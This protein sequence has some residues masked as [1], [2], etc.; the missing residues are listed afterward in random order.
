MQVIPFQFS[1]FIALLPE[2][3]L[4]IT[5]GS[6]ALADIALPGLR[7]KRLLGVYTAIGIGLA[8]LAAVLAVPGTLTADLWFGGMIRNDVAA[9]AFRL[10]ILFAGMV[11][12]LITV[13]SPAIGKEGEF[14]LV[15]TGATLGMCMMA[16][17]ADLIMLYLAIETTSIGLYALAGYLRENDKSAESGLKYFLF[18]AFTSTLLLYGFSLL[19]GFTGSTNLFEIGAALSAGAVPSLPL[20]LSLVLILIGLGF[21]IS[22]VPFHFWTPDVYEGAPTP[23]TAFLSVASKAA[24]FAVLMRVLL[25]AFPGY[26]AWWLQV[27]AAL[28]ALTMTVGNVL[29]MQQRNL[30]RLLAYSSIAQ[31]G[32]ILMGL[33]AFSGQQ[34]DAGVGAVVYYL[35]MYTLTNLA[36]FGVMVLVGRVTGSD[37][38]AD[39]SGLSRRSPG[40][41]LAMLVALLSLGGVP[42]LAGF[43]GKFYLFA[44]VAQNPALLWLFVVGLINAIVSLYYYLVV[45][46]VIYLGQPKDEASLPVSRPYIAALWL[47]AVG[48]ILVGVLIGPFITIAQAAAGNFVQ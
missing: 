34:L 13:D 39:Y 19:Y 8:L 41:A 44:A 23:V 43:F 47:C 6:V 11:T 46:K 5:A 42:P 37:E 17:S 45:L 4:V 3:L 24:G 40:L 33:A 31:A 38:I 48:V 1:H 27:I 21:K 18:G 32:Y 2:V 36:A 14:Y 25:T 30:K 10:M 22:A 29:A 28:S 15:M 26:E 16:L 35:G 12:A 20:V 9:F 7:N